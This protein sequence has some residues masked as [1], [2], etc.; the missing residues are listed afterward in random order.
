MTRE[1]IVRPE[2]EAELSEAF[3]WY[4]ER[5]SGLGSDFLLNVDAAFHSILR[6][7]HL[8]PVVHNNLRRVLIRRFPYQIFFVLEDKRIV[9]LAVFHA[10]R[11][12]RRWMR[13][14]A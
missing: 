2:A 9:V 3:D 4:E 10:R 5:V 13:R 12:P 1:L 6:N 11:N 14:K 7:P 8:F